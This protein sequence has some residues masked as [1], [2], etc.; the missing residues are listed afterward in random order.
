MS[1]G[2]IGTNHADLSTGG[3]GGVEVN[4]SGSRFTMSGTA[5]I[6]GNIT[7]TNGGGVLI[8]EGGSFEKNGGGTIG[9]YRNN[10]ASGDTTTHG[11]AVFYNVGD[12]DYYYRDD[13]LDT[14]DDIS[15]SDPLPTSPGATIGNWTKTPW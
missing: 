6:S 8:T 15:T 11:H 14:G 12:G 1:G 7:N 9:D 10:I 5:N 13:K 4:G 2:E 3:G